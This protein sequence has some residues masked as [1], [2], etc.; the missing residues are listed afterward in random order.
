[1]ALFADIARTAG[2]AGNDV[3]NAQTANSQQAQADAA[4]KLKMLLAQLQIQGLQQKLGGPQSPE[5]QKIAALKRIFGDKYTDQIGQ[6]YLGLGPAPPPKP[7]EYKPYTITGPDGTPAVTYAAQVGDKLVMRNGQELPQ[8]A[9]PYKAPSDKPDTSTE[10]DQRYE[11]IQTALTMKKPVSPEDLAWA[12]AYTKRKT[13]GPV[14]AFNL[15][16]GGGITDDAIDMAA[17]TYRLTGQMPSLG[18]GSVGLRQKILNRA[19]AQS[20]TIASG[21]DTP[22]SG[23]N[24]GADIVTQ[25]AS[26]TAQTGALGQLQRTRSAVGAF[27][28]TALKNLDL[29]TKAAEKVVDSGSPWVNQPLRTVNRGALGS[30]DMAAYDAARQVALTEVARVV[31]NPNLTGVL[32]DEGRQEIAQAAGPNASLAMVKSAVD[33]LKRDMENRKKS[34]D[35]EIADLTKQIR[36]G[37]IVNRS[38]APSASPALSRPSAN[39]VVEQ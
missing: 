39:V 17:T 16:Q 9:Q 35:E 11:R 37:G 10:E 24:A 23:E 34:L 28:S 36:S 38:G 1:M 7:M 8:S 26:Y 6:T 27:E 21:N 15:Q 18:L 5:E 25:R 31:N 12:A 19:A 3:Q 22:T 4:N 14:T 32:T 33:I 30:A 2:S 20:K 29:F 13:L